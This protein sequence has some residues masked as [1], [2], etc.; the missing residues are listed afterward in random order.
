[1]SEIII[2][3]GAMKAIVAEQWGSGVIRSTTWNTS[4]SCGLSSD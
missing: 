4:D 3:V 1:M 2:V